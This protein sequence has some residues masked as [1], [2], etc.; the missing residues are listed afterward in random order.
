VSDVLHCKGQEVVLPQV[1]EGAEAQQLKH[2]S[3]I[4]INPDPSRS[5]SLS[6]RL[7]PCCE[8]TF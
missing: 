2:L 1:V 8:S 3:S 6:L 7:C 5:V 4:A